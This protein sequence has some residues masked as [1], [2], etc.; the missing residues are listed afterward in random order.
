MSVESIYSKEAL[1]KAVKEKIQAVVKTGNYELDRRIGGL[2]IPTLTLIEGDNDSGKSVLSQQIAY[3]ALKDG[4]RVRYVTTENTVR[5]LIS[6]MESLSFNI[7]W[8]FISGTFRITPLQV[9]GLTWDSTVSKSYLSTV[10][11]F[12]KN[13]VNSDIIIIDS[14]TYL[15]THAEEKDV[16][17]F[18]SDIR[19]MVDGEGKAIFFT[20]H[21]F[22]FSQ[23]MLIRIR[24]IC[25]GHIKLVIKEVRDQTVRFI[26]V[27]KLRGASKT[28]GSI[29]G[30]VVDPAFGIKVL[31]FSQAKA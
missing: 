4:F 8:Y 22:A 20:I 5:S 15:V 6:Q 18:F 16:L 24:S 3:G 13:D 7:T 12:I 17:E 21:T 23:D 28:T 27:A 30:F 25:D 19:N 31:P 29:I 2:P 10:L 14:L 26:D 9:T 11:K 1:L